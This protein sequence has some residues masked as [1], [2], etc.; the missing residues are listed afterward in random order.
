M[1]SGWTHLFCCIC[2]E[3]LEPEDCAVDTDGKK[4]DA[5]KGS[6]ALQAGI[7]EAEPEC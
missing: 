6:C 3:V 4:W 7:T 2:F 1:S 5:C